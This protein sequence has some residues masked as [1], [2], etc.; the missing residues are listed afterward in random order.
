MEAQF[1]PVYGILATDVN[2]DGKTDVVLGGNQHRSKPEVGRYDASY[3]LL[4]EGLGDGI[5]MP[6]SAEYSG[7]NLDGEIRAFSILNIKGKPVMLVGRND[8][9]IEFLK[10]NMPAIQPN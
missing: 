8:D 2:N 5:L 6:V 10:I 1:S 7:I 4:L 3:G 9:A